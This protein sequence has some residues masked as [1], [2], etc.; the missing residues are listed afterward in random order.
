MFRTGTSSPAGLYKREPESSA[1]VLH[2]LREDPV[3]NR[4]GENSQSLASPEDSVLHRLRSPEAGRMIT[5]V[6]RCGRKSPNSL[7]KVLQA[8]KS[9]FQMWKIARSPE[10]PAGV[11]ECAGC[12]KKIHSQFLLRA[13]SLKLFHLKVRNVKTICH[14]KV[15]QY[16]HED[17]L[18]CGCCNCRLGEVSTNM[19]PWWF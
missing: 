13:V 9:F 6:N 3:L 5:E 2:R 10:A 14:F 15:E 7:C 18:K 16:W 8:L 17:C 4:F 1:S 12:T 19:I 11:R